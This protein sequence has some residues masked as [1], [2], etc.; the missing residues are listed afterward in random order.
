MVL[1][2]ME[3]GEQGSDPGLPL[4][5]PHCQPGFEVQCEFRPLP[6]AI[7]R[8]GTDQAGGKQRESSM[9]LTAFMP[10]SWSH[11]CRRHYFVQLANTDHC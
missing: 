4:P 5:E 9:S 1:G 11:D 6:V 3:Q 8:S 7:E 10:W 2:W